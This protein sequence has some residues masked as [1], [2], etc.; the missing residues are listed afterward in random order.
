MHPKKTINIFGDILRKIYF[1]KENNN[2]MYKRLLYIFLQFLIAFNVCFAYSPGD[3]E[4]P[5]YN[6]ETPKHL[7]ISEQINIFFDENN[8]ILYICSSEDISNI[9]ITIYKNYFYVNDITISLIANSPATYSISDYE[10]G[11][12]QMQIKIRSKLFNVSLY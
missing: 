12:Y 7:P 1:C 10:K 11:N 6:N 8:G 9:T 4:S 5:H 3:K 2:N